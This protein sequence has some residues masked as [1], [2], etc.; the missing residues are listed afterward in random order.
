MYVLFCRYDT[1]FQ[2]ACVSLLN[3]WQQWNGTDNPFKKSDLTVFETSQIIQFLA[4]L[5]KSDNLNLLK[6]KAMQDVYD[7]N[8]NGNCEILLRY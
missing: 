7:F 5:L 1:S 4:L 8:S 6:I 2:D 3:R